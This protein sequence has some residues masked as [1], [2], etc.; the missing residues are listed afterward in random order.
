MINGL[1]T[2]LAKSIINAE[3][4]ISPQVTNM[5][6]Y[7]R[8]D[9]KATLLSLGKL[10]KMNEQAPLIAA[11]L[12]AIPGYKGGF[13]SKA[14]TGWSFVS[15]ALD[16]ESAITKTN[17]ANAKG[18]HADATKAAFGGVGSIGIGYLAGR[19]LITPFI[20]FAVAAGPVGWV[21]LAV[22]AAAVG[23]LAGKG[24]T[25]VGEKGA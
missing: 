23:Y 8:A 16:T 17:E 25:W 1:D 22:G 5:K 7:I 15:L 3:M 9:V 4:G 18:Q 6:N 14:F 12:K 2:K 10:G 11:N 21:A 20:S 13:A 19:L 24:G